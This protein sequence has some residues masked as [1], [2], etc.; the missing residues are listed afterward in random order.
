MRIP[1]AAPG[2]GERRVGPPLRKPIGKG[3]WLA[4]MLSLLGIWI[5]AKPTDPHKKLAARIEA[6]TAL[7]QECKLDD[8]RAALV[9]LKASKAS[10]SELKPLQDAIF[11]AAATCEKKRLRVKA[12]NDARPQIDDA[13]RA[14]QLDKAAARLAAFRKKW[15]DDADTREREERIDGQRV[16]QLLDEAQA[17]LNRSDRVCLE[18]KLLAAEKLKRPEAE[19]RIKTL[20]DALS[21]LL[22][23]TLLGQPSAQESGQGGAAAGHAAALKTAAPARAEAPRS[24]LLTTSPAVAQNAQTARRFLAEAERDMGQNNYKAALDKADKCLALAET[25]NRDCQALRQKAERLQR[26]LQRCLASGADWVDDH[27]Q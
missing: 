10:A 25:G 23:A 21:R 14:G 6:A 17:C 15:G 18:S 2:S 27:C 22:E 11:G 24:T 26:E 9:T 13:V 16:T 3:T 12:W 19:A 8:A 4:V 5:V 7:A 1:P 20:R